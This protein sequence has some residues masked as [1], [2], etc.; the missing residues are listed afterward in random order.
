M[1]RVLHTIKPSPRELIVSQRA[2]SPQA[3]VDSVSFHLKSKAW[4]RPWISFLWFSQPLAW[5]SPGMSYAL[6]Q[7]FFVLFISK[8]MVLGCPLLWQGVQAESWLHSSPPAET[9]LGRVLEGDLHLPTAVT[10]PI[11]C[12]SRRDGQQRDQ[13]LYDLSFFNL[14]FSSLFSGPLPLGLWGGCVHSIVALLKMVIS[15]GC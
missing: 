9:F 15:E 5:A 10:F 7:S 1:L 4:L 6:T 12:P 2:T 3:R 11:S 8:H 14:S 13:H